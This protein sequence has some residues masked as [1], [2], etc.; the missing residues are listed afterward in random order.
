MSI[1]ETIRA[2][3]RQRIKKY[4]KLADAAWGKDDPFAAET[5]ENIISELQS[6]IVFT[7]TLPEQPVEEVSRPIPRCG[8]GRHFFM[9]EKTNKERP[10]EGL[11]EEIDSYV[12]KN[13]L[14]NCSEIVPVAHH[15]A[16]WG[17]EHLKK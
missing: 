15:F 5:N 14:V 17:A 1:K 16:Q 13:G 12:Y 3:I 6:L 10:V 9:V 7:Y 4:G 8:I 11:E 2:E